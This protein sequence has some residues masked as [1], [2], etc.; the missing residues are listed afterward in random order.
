MNT[1]RPSAPDCV[2]TVASWPVAE[3][4]P[5]STPSEWWR[6][7]VI[8]Q[9]YPRSF[10]DANGDGIGD[11]AGIASKLAYVADLGVDAVWISPFFTS[12]MRDF[13]YD[14]SDYCDVDPMFGSL[15][16]FRLLLGRAHELGL[17]ILID[18][19]FS[20]TSDQHPWFTES[21]ASR[22]NAKADWYVWADAK[23]DGTAPN[24]WL[25]IFGGVA[26]QWDTRRNQYFLHNFLTSQPD[27]NV[28]NPAV[29]DALLDAARFW[30]EL[31][32]DGFRLDV[33]NFY[34]HDLELRDN[35]PVGEM[36]R[37][38]AVRSS[39][40]Y[41]M[42][43]HLHDKSQPENLLFLA[44]LRSL[45]DEYPGIA[46]VGEIGDEEPLVRIAEYTGG[47]DKLH[48]GYSFDL[49]GVRHDAPYVRRVIEK[50]EAVVTDGWPCWSVGN[51]DTV[52][53]RTRWGNGD[54]G[55]ARA[56]L[57]LIMM[58]RGTP[59]V[60]QGEELGLANVTMTFA[61]LQDPF[62]IEF[63]P[64]EQGRDGC[65]T[66][67]P[68][69]S[70]V[71]GG[72]G[73]IATTKP[74]LPVAPEHIALNAA[75]QITDSESMLSFARR[76]L[77]WRKTQPAIQLG[78]LRLIDTSNSAGLGFV[79]ALGAAR[80]VCAVNVSDDAASLDLSDLALSS[81]PSVMMDAG[82]GTPLALTVDEIRLA[83]WSAAVARLG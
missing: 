75:S 18:L 68:W 66:P 28:Q 14:V 5:V 83:P 53:V 47:G 13:G 16:D 43:R 61:D 22:D 64:D 82:F 70:S 56:A 2:E 4:T 51:H 34:M 40:P 65:R 63:W 72:F 6:S 31:G 58:M 69:D 77:A 46:M 30:L 38:P 19:V 15:D 1:S 74:W 48:M 12:P 41:S 33:V 37:D 21:R 67:M 71:H 35:P 8:Y 11:L 3:L 29:Q 23:P 57:A 62:G 25:S 24:N 60:F 42:Q 39:N 79:R 55:V 7:G 49:L 45:C 20:H 73:T 52:R 50:F 54:K 9:V 80:L 26:W 44:R 76:V 17:K 81:V 27:L 59:C 10:A 32:V 36:H 78:S